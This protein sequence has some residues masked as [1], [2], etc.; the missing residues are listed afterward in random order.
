MS[1]I[2]CGHGVYTGTRRGLRSVTET[3][4]FCEGLA[5]AIVRVRD[6]GEGTER[7]MNR[8][9]S[10]LMSFGDHLD[11]LRRRLIFV[12][13][14]IVPI[15]VLGLVFGGRILEFLISPLRAALNRAGQPESLLATTPL[16]PF[17][18]YIKVSLALALLV[19]TP[20][21]LIQLWLFIAPGLYKRERRFAYF[22]IPLS[23]VL[24]ALGMVF[25]Y[26]VLLPISLYFL[27]T[28]NAALVGRPTDRSVI[29]DG[30]VLPSV[31]VLEGV[32]SQADFDA[33]VVGPGSYWLN[34]RSNQLQFVTPDGDVRTVVSR[35]DG[36]IAQEFRVGAYVSLVFTFALVF[37]I[38]SQLPVVMLLLSWVGILRPSDV[39]KFRR[40]IGFGCAV[41]GAVLTP[42][43]PISMVALGGALYLLFEFGVA[44]MRFVPASVIAGKDLDGDE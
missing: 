40:Q 16:E 23:T 6:T 24:S 37:A 22:L 28:F 13:L 4:N 10:A 31:P 30:L 36:L 1:G 14:G 32:P 18:A 25:L 43:D 29:P 26:S 41:A 19:G 42:Q 3:R 21:M 9:D 5:A 17:V 8:N 35:G 34:D 2:R 39:T 33:G 7:M 15:F 20:W 11:E 38:S 27:I 44:L 12:M